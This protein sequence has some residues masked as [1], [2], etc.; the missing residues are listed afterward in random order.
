MPGWSGD[1]E[2]LRSLD[3]ILELKVSIGQVGRHEVW[4]IGDQINIWIDSQHWVVAVCIGVSKETK[5]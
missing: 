4:G 2:E 5:R 1:T 3:R